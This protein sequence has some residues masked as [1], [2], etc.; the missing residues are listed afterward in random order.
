MQSSRS[1]KMI[2]LGKMGAKLDEK[3]RLVLEKLRE[4]KVIATGDNSSSG[5]AAHS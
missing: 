2:F 3:R 1:S 5:S 4:K